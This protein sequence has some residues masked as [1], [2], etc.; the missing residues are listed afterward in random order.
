MIKIPV[1]NN[2]NTKISDFTIEG[3]FEF[4]KALISQVVRVLNS[5]M[6]VK[7]GVTKT[8]GEVRGGG[9]KPY[10]QK[11]TGRARAGSI[12]SPLW[13]GGGITFG[14]TGQSRILEIP[15]K[16]RLAAF[17]QLLAKQAEDGDVI[18]IDKSVLEQ[19]KA[20]DA[21]AVLDKFNFDKKVI[22]IISESEK[23]NSVNFR[24]LSLVELKLLNNLSISDLIKNSKLV[25]SLDSLEQLKKRLKSEN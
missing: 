11:G 22:M 7:A 13:R 21:S 1:Y 4:N 23:A 18:G 17:W 2:E 5:R 10:R 3:D 20:K 25:V 14:P 15:K 9:R 24:N 19:K 8:K 6:S 12:R 16:M